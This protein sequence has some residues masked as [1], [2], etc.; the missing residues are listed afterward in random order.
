[1]RVHYLIF[2]LLFSIIKLNAQNPGVIKNNNIENAD[3]VEIKGGVVNIKHADTVL[4]KVYISDTKTEILL[5]GFR[6]TKDS[7]GYLT[8]LHFIRPNSIAYS[9]VLE[10]K[11]DIPID[12]FDY[13]GGSGFMQ[14]YWSE[15]KKTGTFSGNFTSHTG[16]TIWFR[17]PYKYA[18]KIS[19]VGIEGV[20]NKN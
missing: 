8:F 12:G 16:F 9:F 1:M 5:D 10:I 18:P 3:R 17:T 4:V 7:L 15:D 13:R 6:Q 2:S 19:I 14:G 20:A 11:L